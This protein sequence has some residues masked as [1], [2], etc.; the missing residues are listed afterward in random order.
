MYKGLSISCFKFIP[1]KD[2]SKQLPTAAEDGSHK[3]YTKFLFQYQLLPKD[4]HGYP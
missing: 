2:D 4:V 3:R 1:L